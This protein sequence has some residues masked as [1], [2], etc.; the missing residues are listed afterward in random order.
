MDTVFQVTQGEQLLMSTKLTLFQKYSRAFEGIWGHFRALRVTKEG[1]KI[2]KTVLR[3][4]FAK[5]HLISV[6][7][8][9]LS[10]RS[11][12]LNVVLTGFTTKVQH[13][14]GKSFIIVWWLNNLTLFRS[15]QNT[16]F[17]KMDRQGLMLNTKKLC[18]TLTIISYV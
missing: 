13:K 15:F 18:N 5:I 11:L 7:K 14:T 3:Q 17:P 12:K 10:R 4:Q 1:I 2:S 9:A 16:L 6:L 8:N